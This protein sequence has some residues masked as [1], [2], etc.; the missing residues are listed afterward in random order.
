MKVIPESLTPPDRK[1][2]KYVKPQIW[3]LYTILTPYL[4]MIGNI[5]FLDIRSSYEI[6][7][8]I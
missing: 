8:H 2:G 5:Y 4:L 6:S 3:E 1:W 7:M